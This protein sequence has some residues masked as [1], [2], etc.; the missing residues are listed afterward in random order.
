[1]AS[2][3]CNIININMDFGVDQTRVW[4]IK[5]TQFDSTQHPSFV[6]PPGCL[7][8]NYGPGPD[9]IQNFN[10]KDEDSYHLSSQRYSICWRRERGK[11]SLCF[12]IGYFGMSNV[13]S[14]VPA[15]ST[16]TSDWTKLSG[17]TDSICC[18][19]DTPTANCG[20]SG[21]DGKMFYVRLIS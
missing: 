17:S 9:R 14:K 12:A 4:D 18:S 19:E 7:Q 2:E 16:G 3:M 5:V 15:S 13:P 11:C 8:W 10:F 1:M 20:S 6:A 21:A